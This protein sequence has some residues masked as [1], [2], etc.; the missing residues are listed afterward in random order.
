[1]LTSKIHTQWDAEFCKSTTYQIEYTGLVW[2]DLWLSSTEKAI[3]D[4]YQTHGD[5][6]TVAQLQSLER[7]DE[8]F[9]N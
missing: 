3:L 7:K 8:T 6:I 5:W 1:M 2:N 4:H 9:D